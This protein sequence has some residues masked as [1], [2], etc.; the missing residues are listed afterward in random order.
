MAFDSETS[1]DGVMERR[2]E[3]TVAGERVPAV[4]WAPEGAKGGR[5]LICM[6]HGGTQHKR[7]PGIKSRALQLAAT[8]GYATLAID[9]PGHG[10]RVTKEERERAAA[11][12][13]ERVTSG[14]RDGPPR[15]TVD[16]SPQHTAEWKEALDYA[17]ALDFV[18][19]G[20]VGY[21]GVS[22]GTRYGVPFVA[23]EPRVT[24]AVFGLFPL[25]PG[26]FAEAAAS[27]TIPLQ[28]VFQ[29]DDELMTRDGG[30]A[31][32]N[33]FAAKEKTMHINPGRHVGIPDFERAAWDDFYVR[34]LS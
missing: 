7:T 6:G 11:A 1:I 22:M 33:A 20:K 29:W 5:P 14:G 32:F 15:E 13:R 27:I 12:A 2:F 26:A 8:R 31:L 19:D 25:M 18:G 9:G 16:R 17:Q 30:I 3:L 10:D 4:I 24:C 21:W 23:A 28:F 34:H